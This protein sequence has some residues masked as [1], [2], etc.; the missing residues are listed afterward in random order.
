MAGLSPQDQALARLL[1]ATEAL[2]T[3]FSASVNESLAHLVTSALAA[4]DEPWLGE[5]LASFGWEAGR[6]TRAVDVR[7]LGSRLKALTLEGLQEKGRGA[8][9][10]VLKVT[11]AP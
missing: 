8:Y 2:T 5:L 7:E 4:S 1:A 6:F 11:P 9:A 10:V 3:N